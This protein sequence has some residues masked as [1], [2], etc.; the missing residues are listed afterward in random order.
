M[1]YSTCLEAIRVKIARAV[2]DE[3]DK[4][5]ESELFRREMADVKPIDRGNR[6]APQRPK[7]P[8]RVRRETDTTPSIEDVFS[9]APIDE[10]CPDILSFCRDGIQKQTFKRLRQGKL[11]CQQVLDL[12]GL[13]VTQARDELIAFL[14]DCDVMGVRH[15]LIIHGKGYR[16][17]EKPVIKPM[18]NRWLRQAP[19][20]LA[21]HSAQPEDGGS[22]AVYVLL[23][24]PGKK[25]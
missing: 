9:D 10:P 18:L 24:K 13:T 8:L 12:H 7:K 21:F 17:K 4:L 22:G 14:G 11:G 19:T 5:D 6:I 1:R 15:A 23:K 16:S 20:V 2:H 25:N 3:N